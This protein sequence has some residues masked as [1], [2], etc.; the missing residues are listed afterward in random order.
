MDGLIYVPREL[1]KEVFEQLYEEQ[2]TGHQ[3]IDKI[4]ERMQRTYY[5]LKM[6]KYVEG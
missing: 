2:T 3:G 4:L 1:R 6:R 5:F